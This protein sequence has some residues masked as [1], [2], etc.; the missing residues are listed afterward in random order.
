MKLPRGVSGD[1][2]VRTLQQ[3]GYSIV[4]QKG[5]HVRLQHPGPPVHKVTVPLHNPLKTGTLHG[6]LAEV[7]LMRSITV[8]SLAQLL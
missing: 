5:S 1:R 4:R 3:V 2:L 7:A 8:D 6:I